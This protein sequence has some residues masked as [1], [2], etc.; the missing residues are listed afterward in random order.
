MNDSEFIDLLNLY[1]DH[2]ISAVDA[3]RLEA[4]V[5]RDPERQKIYRQYCRMQKACKLLTADFQPE[6]APATSRKVIAFNHVAAVAAPR[7]YTGGFYTVGAVAAAAACVAII[8]IGR[9]RQASIE[10]ATFA[11]APAPQVAPAT[12]VAGTTVSSQA[13]ADVP[14]SILAAANS[15]TTASGPQSL[16]RMSRTTLVANPLLLTGSSQADAVLAAAIEQANAQFAWMQNVKLTPIQQPSSGPSL[17]FE[18]QSVAWRPERRTLDNRTA[19]SGASE[20]SAFQ[21]MK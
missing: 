20:M 21:F 14:V 4:E 10:T 12:L 16:G 5:Q 15:P 13:E 2:E 6:T 19:P 1:L 8:F 17:R 3:A 7:H 9:G 11:A 18:T